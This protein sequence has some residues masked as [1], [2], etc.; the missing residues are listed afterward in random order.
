MGIYHVVGSGITG[1]FLA[2]GLLVFLF[3]LRVAAAGTRNGETV[4]DHV[5]V[6]ECR[7]R[8]IGAVGVP[9]IAVAAA[10]R[11]SLGVQ[12]GAAFAPVVQQ[13]PL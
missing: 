1:I 12:R 7:V 10:D 11:I 2:E 4:F 3:Q 8:I 13:F 5:V 9:D 6:P